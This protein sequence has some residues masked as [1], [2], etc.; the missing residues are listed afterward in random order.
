MAIGWMRLDL[1]FWHDEK[2]LG[3]ISAHGEAAAFKAIKLYCLAHSNYGQ[4][5]LND[6]LSRPWLEEEL[7]LRGKRLTTFL[8]SLA[9]FKV[10]DGI[11]LKEGIITSARLLKEGKKKQ[12]SEDRHAAMAEKRWRSV[13]NSG[14]NDAQ[15]DA[16]ADA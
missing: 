9:Q 5:N 1:N 12:D 3:L 10:I 15:A 4:I 11:Y 6:P 16:Q 14:D 13:E 8:E 7:K 2:F